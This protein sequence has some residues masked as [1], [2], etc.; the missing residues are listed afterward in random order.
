MQQ[1]AMV[2]RANVTRVEPSHLE[3][4]MLVY[5][6]AEALPD[7]GQAHLPAK[8]RSIYTGPHRVAEVGLGRGGRNVRIELT[9]A[10]RRREAVVN[11]DS[12]VIFVGELQL[13]GPQH[14]LQPQDRRGD[15]RE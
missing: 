12:V 8:L 13:D 10:S 2:K 15:D 1:V 11:V 5:V 7:P 3:E 14:E 9:G 6:S 4:G